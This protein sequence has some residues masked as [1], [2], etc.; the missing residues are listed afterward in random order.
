MPKRTDVRILVALE[1]EWKHAKYR[2]LL[3]ITYFLLDS[4]VQSSKNKNGEKHATSYSII[5][6]CLIKVENRW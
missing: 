3:T 4:V 2:L 1:D 6:L 5:N